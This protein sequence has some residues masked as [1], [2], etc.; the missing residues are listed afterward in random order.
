[1]SASEVSLIAV[2]PRSVER[3]WRAVLPYIEKSYRRSE[4]D[5][6]IDLMANVMWRKKVLWLLVQNEEIVGAGITALYTLAGEGKMCKIE[7]FAADGGI[8]KWLHLRSEIERYAKAEGCDR[9]AID[10]RLGWQKY[11][12]DYEVTAV[13]MEKRLGHG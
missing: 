1:L 4:I 2:D 8:S 6:P 3:L 13:I 5:V 9:V 12:L 10:A 11:L 7:H